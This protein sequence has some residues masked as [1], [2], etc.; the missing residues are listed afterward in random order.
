MAQLLKQ[1]GGTGPDDHVPG[2]DV[3]PLGYGPTEPGTQHVQG[4]MHAADRLPDGFCH[5][6]KRRKVVLIQGRLN[7]IPTGCHLETSDRI[8]RGMSRMA[9][10]AEH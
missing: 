7:L 2:G 8:V 6:G 4:Q 3:Q 5:T 1:R 9:D 10:Y